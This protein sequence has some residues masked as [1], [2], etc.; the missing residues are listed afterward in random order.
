MSGA[1]YVRVDPQR[2]RRISTGPGEPPRHARGTPAV[3]CTCLNR[4]QAG[5]QLAVNIEIHTEVSIAAG[6]AALTS[7]R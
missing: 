1:D 3:S 6:R 2:D 7:L 4:P 5:K